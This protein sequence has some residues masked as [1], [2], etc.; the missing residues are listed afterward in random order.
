MLH[1][2]CVKDNWEIILVDKGHNKIKKLE[3]KSFCV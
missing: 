1:E 2:H 3:E